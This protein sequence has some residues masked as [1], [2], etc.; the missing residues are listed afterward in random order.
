MEVIIFIVCN[1]LDNT[2][3][4]TS[5]KSLNGTHVTGALTSQ[6]IVHVRGGIS[7]YVALTSSGVLYSWGRNTESQLGGKSNKNKLTNRWYCNQ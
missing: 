5:Q 4:F 3:V 7:H 2:T 6:T 1:I